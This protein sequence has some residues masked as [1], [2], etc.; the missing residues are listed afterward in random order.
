MIIKAAV[1]GTCFLLLPTTSNGAFTRGGVLF[2]SLLFNALISQ[3]ELPRSLQGRPILYKLKNYAM[4][5]PSSFGLAQIVLDLPVI[6]VHILLFSVVL[7][8]LAGLQRTAGKFFFFVLVLSL[9][10][11]CMTAFFRMWGCASKTFDD[12]TKYSGI[13]LLALILYSGYLIPYQAMHPW[14]IWIFWINPLAY[15][16]KALMSNEMSG[17][18]FSCDAPYLIP[19]GPEYT[20]LDY[21]VCTLAGAKPG[22]DYVDGP[23]YLYSSFRYKVSEMWLNVL[24]VF[25]F[26]LLFAALT[27]WAMESKEFGKGGFSTNVFKRPEKNSGAVA[28]GR[29]E[30][31]VERGQVPNTVYPAGDVAVQAQGIGAAGIA[32][33]NLVKGSV[34]AWE[35]LDYV[36]S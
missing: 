31:D 15:A 3:A 14:F 34:F 18:R 30:P 6:I 17:L 19:Y 26:W 27:A 35:D 9:A 1:V 4:Y 32:K 2:F 24:A 29:I 23:D 5:R 13:L 8:F 25:L 36:V 11:L 7:Y 28:G 33:E 12:A 10:T 21:R 22:R 20:N 16:F